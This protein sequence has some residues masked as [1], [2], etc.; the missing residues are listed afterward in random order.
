[1]I[2]HSILYLKTQ[3]RK[4]HKMYT[5]QKYDKINVMTSQTGQERE[6]AATPHIPMVMMTCQESHLS[7][8]SHQYPKL[9]K[10]HFLSPSSFIS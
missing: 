2:Y 4:M 8:H 10:G 7:A 6:A 3:C 5:R 1:M 9:L